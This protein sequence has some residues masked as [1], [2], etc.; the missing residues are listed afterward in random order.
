[1]LI[2]VFIFIYYINSSAN[3]AMPYALGLWPA[4]GKAALA[5]RIA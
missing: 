1:M 3:A 2:I 4:F 5:Q